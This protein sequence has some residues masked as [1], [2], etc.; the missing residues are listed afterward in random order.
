MEVVGFVPCCS[1]DQNPLG[2]WGHQAG[3]SLVGFRVQHTGAWSEDILDESFLSIPLTAV[4]PFNSPSA[5][6]GT[7]L[8]DNAIMLPIWL[9]HGTKT[10]RGERT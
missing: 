5:T 1:T 9:L 6:A 2:L 7:D 8:C 4:A 10:P 3:T